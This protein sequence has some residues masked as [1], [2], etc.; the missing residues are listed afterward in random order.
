MKHTWRYEKY[1]KPLY[2][3]RIL[4]LRGKRSSGSAGGRIIL[5][6]MA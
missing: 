4:K 1:E 3:I 6:I 5:N 2:N